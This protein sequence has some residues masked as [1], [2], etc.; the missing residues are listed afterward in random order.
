MRRGDCASAGETGTWRTGVFVTTWH[1][2][3]TVCGADR[4]VEQMQQTPIC[5]CGPSGGAAGG[6]PAMRMCVSLIWHQA[7]VHEVSI[8]G[9]CLR[10]PAACKDLDDD[11]AATAAGAWARVHA[12]LI[13]LLC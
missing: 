1:E 8:D 7:R 9:L 13:G 2:T 5:V 3:A 11:H 12:G 4:W 6:A 10:R